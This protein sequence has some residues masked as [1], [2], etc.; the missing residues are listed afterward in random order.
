[1]THEPSTDCLSLI[2]HFE[3]RKLHAY[4]CP[5]GRLTIGVGHTGPDVYEGQTITNDEATALLKR[6]AHLA[7]LSVNV[8]VKAPLTQHQFDALVSFVFNLGYGNL[9]GSTL[10]KH[11]NAGDYHG[12]A[13]EFAKWTHSRGKILPGLVERRAAEAKLFSN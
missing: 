8:L 12:A 5:A 6:D 9:A 13:A 4:L 3:G 10:L 7:A 1:M 11:L 2:E